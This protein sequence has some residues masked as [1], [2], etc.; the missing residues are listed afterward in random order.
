MKRNVLIV[1]L[2]LIAYFAL[3]GYQHVMAGVS[4]VLGLLGVD[5]AD[6]ARIVKEVP[7][8]GVRSIEISSRGIN[9]YIVRGGAD[10]IQA[11]LTSKSGTTFLHGFEL[12]AEMKDGGILVIEANRSTPWIPVFMRMGADLTVELPANLYE[13]VTLAIGSGNAS[14]ADVEANKIAVTSGSGNIAFGNLS[15]QEMTVRSGSGNITGE[16]FAAGL[17]S[18]ETGS[19]NIKLADGSAGLRA[20]TGSGNIR[21]E[22]EELDRDAELQTGSGNVTVLLRKEPKSLRFDLSARSGNSSVE[23][24]HRTESA[25][26]HR[27]MKGT[28]GAGETELTVRTGSGN[29]KLGYRD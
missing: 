19:G 1:A 6:A 11:V 13:S 29:I 15:A 27:G 10:R 14:V 8:S 3:G 22:L 23:W 24:P 12:N 7:S 16:R 17:L 26:D 5:R 4:G 28:I 25:A 21:L 20:K 18:A 2:L 9:A